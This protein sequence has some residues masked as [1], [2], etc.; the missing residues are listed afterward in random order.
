MASGD[1]TTLANVKGWLGIAGANT[2]DDPI[3]TR[4][5]SAVSAFVT[6]YLNRQILLATY[7]EIY[8]KGWGN[9]ITPENWPI[10]AVTSLTSN[11]NVIPASP[12]GIQNGYV[13]NDKTIFLNGYAFGFGPFVQGKQFLNVTLVY[14]AGY[15]TV[16]LDLEQAVI[17][18]VA[19]R[20]REAERIGQRSKSMGGEVISFNVVNMP[21]DVVDTLAMYKK[22]VV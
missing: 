4:L 12:D 15:A 20:Y 5:I 6:N 3:L 2:N 13:F 17:H 10:T 9:T 21:P 16:P 18:L 8:T 19:L 22:V 7:T 14:T 11:G 1:L